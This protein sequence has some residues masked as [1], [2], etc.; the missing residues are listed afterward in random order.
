MIDHVRL[1]LVKGMT[2]RAA[3]V[4][5]EAF[6]SPA[7]ALRARPGE[8]RGLPDIG[9]TLAGRLADPPSPGRARTELR[10]AR[11]LGL[12]VLHLGGEGYPRILREIPD[13]PV[14]LY[15]RGSLEAEREGVAV[16]GARRA[17]AYGRIQ[18]ERFGAGLARSGVAV[19]S[20]LARGVDGAAHRGALSEGGPTLAVL[21]CGLDRVYPPEHAGLA[22]EIAARGALLSELPLGTPPLARHFPQRNRIIAGLS[23][24]VVVVE[25][26]L[27]SGSLITAR[28]A[29]ESGRAVFGVPG[30]IDL[31]LA[32]GPHS[33]IRDG[34]ILVTSPEQVLQELGVVPLAPDPPAPPPADPLQAE[35]LS[36]LDPSEPRGVEEILV[37][38]E[39]NAPVVLAALTALEVS[40]RVRV[41]PDRRYVR[42]T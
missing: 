17:S 41:F 29:N 6:G 27:R 12:H 22:G 33:L 36:V 24:G 16:V 35:I 25:G 13:P 21:G 2:P 1:N 10:R 4:L 32:A 23:R 39:R 9:P 11:K 3:A 5:L 28:L 26:R 40:G 38:V 31:D 42:V 7:G 20:G 8:L 37:G 34:A 15:V 19:I 14:L 30:R 18:A